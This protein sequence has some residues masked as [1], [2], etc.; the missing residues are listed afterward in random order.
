M[1]T[2][3]SEGPQFYNQAYALYS[4]FATTGPYVTKLSLPQERAFRKWVAKYRVPFNA[5]AG[6]GAVSD[7]DMRGF[8]KAT[9][10]RPYRGGHFPDTYKTPYDTTF[11]AESR[12]ATRSN[13]FRWVGQNLVDTRDGTVVFSPAKAQNERTGAPVTAALLAHI[14]GMR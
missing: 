12:Y 1:A 3:S 11:S 10:G 14:A 2:F 4:P 13:P 9:K 7:Y 6:Q 8:W 5:A